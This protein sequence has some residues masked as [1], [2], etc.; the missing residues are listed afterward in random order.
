MTTA[1]LSSSL[2]IVK[3][4]ASHAAD[5]SALAGRFQLSS[6][7]P[8]DARTHGFLVS[9]FCERDYAAFAERGDHFYVVLHETQ[10][11]G[12]L[13]GYTRDQ[14]E[15][16]ALV[17][18]Q[19]ADRYQEPFLIIKQICV[20]GD[21]SKHGLASRL[22]EHAARQVPRFRIFAAIVL[23]PLNLPSIRFHEKLQFEKVLEITPPDG[24]LRGVWSRQ[25]IEEDHVHK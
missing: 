24:L 15:P 10:V 6:L 5:I 7:S 23:K 8:Q 22:Y 4:R 18:R 12:F 14:I 16:G 17:D 25:P 2:Q 11:V 9:G 20:R 19:L 3:A 1:D 13:L 21:F